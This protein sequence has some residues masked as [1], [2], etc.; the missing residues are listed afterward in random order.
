MRQIKIAPSL[1]AADAA[2]LGAEVA[3]VEKAGAEW[4]HLDIMDGH[5]VPNLSFGP[6]IVKALR[7][8]SEMVF[9][10]HLMITDPEKYI[11]GFIDAGADI[12]TVHAET[13]DTNGL[14]RVAQYLHSKEVKAGV[15]VKPGTAAESIEDVLD[16]YDMVLIMTVEPGFGGQSYMADMESKIKWFAHMADNKYPN[17]E[18]EVDGGIGVSTA[19]HAAASGANIFVA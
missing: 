9:D 18:I 7:A 3:R 13:L 10:V 11:D 19:A 16:V 17:L 12:I 1:L 4:L 6:Y 8:D 2:R 14:R 5:F 15:S